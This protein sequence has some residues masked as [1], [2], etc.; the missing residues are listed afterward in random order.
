[1]KALE[2]FCRR[3]AGRGSIRAKRSLR[4]LR[5]A[6]R[7]TLWGIFLTVLLMAGA[8]GGF[9]Q[10]ATEREG[11]PVLPNPEAMASQGDWSLDREVDRELY[12]LGPGDQLLLVLEGRNLTRVPLRV[13]P[14]G[15]IDWEGGL[16]V[17]VGGM[18]LAQAEEAVIAA[19][20]PLMREVKISLLLL[21]PRLLDVHVLGLV[22]KPGIVRLRATD[23]L[24]TAL[25]AAGGATPQG[26]GRFVE[27]I[28]DEGGRQRLDLYPYRLSGELAA[29]PYCPADR[30]IVV[31]ARTDTV[32]VI[33]EV[34][35]PG[36][37]EWREGETIKELLGFAQGFTQDA[38]P[39]SVL[40]ERDE[41]EVQIR[42]LD[43]HES[44]LAL[45]PG[46]VLVVGSRRPML[47]RVYLEGAGERMGELYLSPGE[48]LGD[49]VHRIGDTRGSALP[50]QAILE[51]K[52]TERDRFFTFNL[53]EVLQGLGPVDMPIENEDVLYVPVRS[54]QVFVL[55]EV[56]KPGALNY[57][58]SW[59][60]GQYL[61]LAGGTT[62]RGSDSKLRVIGVDG[63][64]RKVSADDH[65]H[66]GDILSVRKSNVAILSDVLLTAAT[67]S[68]VILAINAL[69]K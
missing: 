35:R 26:S 53:K 19:M 4:F 31:P 34:N 36:S 11:L 56:E 5:C 68:G 29:N 46:D 54:R 18:S 66:R 33:G 14:E 61:A 21:E 67:L 37:Y 20:K 7:K 8:G 55:G 39:A 42:M 60:A 1:M 15:I 9:A 25:L 27:L 51:R 64:Q 59:T 48:T 30:V 22:A 47:N 12:R 57:I 44:A 40:L 23:R 17:K 65:L 24:D 62:D 58:P 16:H 10:D 38:L 2:Q 6:R 3:S 49:L 45:R 32:Q 63:V 28:D 69:A 13:L 43:E 50:E 41:H 52:G